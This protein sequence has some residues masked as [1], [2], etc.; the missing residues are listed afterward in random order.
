M[1]DVTISKGLMRVDGYKS[2]RSGNK[3]EADHNKSEDF[4]HVPTS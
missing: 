3:G 1:I 2:N 4:S